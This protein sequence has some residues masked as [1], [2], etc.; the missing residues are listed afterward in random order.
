MPPHSRQSLLV[1]LIPLFV[2]LDFVVPEFG[3][4]L[5]HSEIAA[6]IVPM[7]KASIYK[8]AGTIFTHDDVGMTRQS[9]ME[10]SISEAP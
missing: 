2:A 5:R 7:P 3:V 6:I 10:E 9:L 1:V 4:G 8:D